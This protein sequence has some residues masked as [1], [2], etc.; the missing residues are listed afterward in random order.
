MFRIGANHASLKEKH[1]LIPQSSSCGMIHI[2]FVLS[3]CFRTVQTEVT[4]SSV[5]TSPVGLTQTAW[6]LPAHL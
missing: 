1:D 6:H 5:S 4:S 2:E 3:W